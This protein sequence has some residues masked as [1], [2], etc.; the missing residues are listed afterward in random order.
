MERV[1]INTGCMN[2]PA[3]YVNPKTIHAYYNSAMLQ[4][5]THSYVLEIYHNTYH[6][7]MTRQNEFNKSMYLTL[8]E[9]NDNG[10]CRQ[11]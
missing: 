6:I 11:K 4:W 5:V 9:A 7:N 8:D 3:S 2:P 10:T 1:G